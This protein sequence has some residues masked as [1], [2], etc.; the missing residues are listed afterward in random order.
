MPEDVQIV[1]LVCDAT[2]DSP[3]QIQKALQIVQ[4]A[5]AS[6]VNIVPDSQ[7][8]KFMANVAAVPTTIF[9]NNKGEVVGK[10]IIGA[11]IEGYKNELENLL[12]D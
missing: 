4:K 5:N 12:K 7:L 1:G 2:V 3:N 9:V 11:D 8:I 6:F 10:P